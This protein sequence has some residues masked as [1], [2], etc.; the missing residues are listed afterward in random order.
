MRIFFVFVLLLSFL[1][2]ASV[3]D[4]YDSQKRQISPSILT[5]NEAKKLFQDFRTMEEVPFN[6]PVEGCFARATA[7]ARL[8]EKKNIITAKVFAEGRLIAKTGSKRF[9]PVEWSWHVAPV[10]YVDSGKGPVLTVFDPSLFDRPVSMP[11]FLEALESETQ[12]LMLKRKGK[13][14]RHYFGE[15]FQNWPLYKS[16]VKKY[17]WEKNEL[18]FAEKKMKEYSEIMKKGSAQGQSSEK[19]EKAS[20]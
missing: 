13:V 8:A 5:A 14:I 19:N 7:M 2:A 3:P 6:Y 10:L 17:G 9:D 20:Q 15:R 18:V 16:K 1:A 12:F 4:A 11:E